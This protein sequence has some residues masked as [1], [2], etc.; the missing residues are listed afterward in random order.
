MGKS[1]PTQH[2]LLI[3]LDPCPTGSRL[4]SEL[5]R[6]CQ[7]ITSRNTGE[8]YSSK[9]NLEGN[10]LNTAS[11]QLDGRH[12]NQMPPPTLRSIQLNTT[13]TSPSKK[14]IICPSLSLTDIAHWLCCCV[15]TK[16]LPSILGY[17]C[18]ALLIALIAKFVLV[19][20][21]AP[22]QLKILVLPSSPHVTAIQRLIIRPSALSI[23]TRAMNMV[24]RPSPLA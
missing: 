6:N 13:L 12:A 23:P 18:D 9:P 11:M 21:R 20:A 4:R 22:V 24:S 3:E 8:H 16:L 5:I 7:K 17:C 2:T 1:N 10:A 15:T 19:W 14:E